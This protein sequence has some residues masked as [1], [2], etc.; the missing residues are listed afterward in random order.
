MIPS[1][2][3]RARQTSNIN[4][5]LQNRNRNQ[6]S[7]QRSPR[8]KAELL[9]TGSATKFMSLAATDLHDVGQV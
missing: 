7:K 2:N 5:F 9:E 6:M 3:W 4:E 1:R 8:R